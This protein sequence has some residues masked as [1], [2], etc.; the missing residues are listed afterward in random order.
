MCNM[1]KD[2]INDTFEKLKTGNKHLDLTVKKHFIY[3]SELYHATLGNRTFGD[4]EHHFINCLEEYSKSAHSK[5]VRLSNNNLTLE[6]LLEI[7]DIPIEVY[8]AFVE[9][10]NDLLKFYTDEPWI[11]ERRRKVLDKQI[12]EFSSSFTYYDEKED[13]KYR[14]NQELSII[15]NDTTKKNNYLDRVLSAM[16]MAELN[17]VDNNK[18][19]TVLKLFKTHNDFNEYFDY[20]PF[21]N[22]KKDLKKIYKESPNKATKSLVKYLRK[23]YKDE[24]DKARGI[25]L[26]RWFLFHLVYGKNKFNIFMIH[27]ILGYKYSSATKVCQKLFCNDHTTGGNDD[28]LHHTNILGIQEKH[29]D[30]EYYPLFDELLSYL[31]KEK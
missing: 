8:E 12:A 15:G 20:F 11:I 25:Q 17:Q 14:M 4:I 18:Y 3:D 30:E 28:F 6:E 29:L 22:K 7:N 19:I 23:I 24:E 10:V 1:I 9:K 2:R 16:K 27:S 21:N 13:I 31:P 5:R 26:V